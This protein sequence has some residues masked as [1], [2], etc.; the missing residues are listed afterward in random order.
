MLGDSYQTFARLG[1]SFQRSQ[2]SGRVTAQPGPAVCVLQAP[3]SRSSTRPRRRTSFFDGIDTTLPGIYRA[4]R[5]D[6]ASGADALLDAID[7]EVKTPS[8]AFSVDRSLRRRAR[9]G[10]R[11][12]A[13]PAT[14]IGAAR[15]D[16][17]V[18]FMLAI[19]ERQFADAIIAALGISFTA[20]AQPAGTPEAT[21]PF[22]AGAAVR[23][24][25]GVPGQTF[26]V[27]TASRTAA[28]SR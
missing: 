28:R 16:P 7:R 26:D 27:R 23:D 11:P 25:G 24:G 22:A 13:R 15:R 17:D 14:A 10:A 5:Q 21:G 4:L 18:A 9:A 6:A 8:Q 20:I 1:L 3:G 19:K 12:C 2:N